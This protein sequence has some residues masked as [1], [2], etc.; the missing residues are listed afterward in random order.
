MRTGLRFGFDYRSVLSFSP[1]D[2]KNFYHYQERRVMNRPL[3]ADHKREL[4]FFG[5]FQGRE[6]IA[7]SE[8]AGVV[9]R[10]PFR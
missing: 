2:E 5:V 7:N 3:D 8:N 9:S 1:P 10:R 4:S 6:L